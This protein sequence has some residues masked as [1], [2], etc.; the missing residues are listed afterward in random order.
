MEKAFTKNA[1]DEKQV[2]DAAWK[3]NS[4]RE[5][6]ID[7]VSFILSHPQGRRFFWRYLSLC[8]MW[9]TSFTGNSTTFFNEGERNIGLRLMADIN[10]ASPEAYVQMVKE[11]IDKEN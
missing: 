2:K 7:D 9:K 3:S 4:L 11:N 10:E 1:A 8:N 5:R 6:E